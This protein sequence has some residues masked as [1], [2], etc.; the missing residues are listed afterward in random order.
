LIFS[1]TTLTL[2]IAKNFYS[3]N[4]N[5]LHLQKEEDDFKNFSSMN[6]KDALSRSRNYVK[7]DKPY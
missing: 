4:N 5:I 7:I 6:N 3:K 1:S 2:F